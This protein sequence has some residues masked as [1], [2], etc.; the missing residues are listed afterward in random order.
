MGS[1]NRKE[2]VTQ[3][4][5]ANCGQMC[6]EKT[7]VSFRD[8]VGGIQRAVGFAPRELTGQRKELGIISLWSRQPP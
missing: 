7:I 1:K 6:S 4:E 5:M 3:T 2:A 8:S